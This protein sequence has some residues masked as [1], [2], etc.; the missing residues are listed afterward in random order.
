M[1]DSEDEHVEQR[2]LRPCE[3][4]HVKMPDELQQSAFEVRAPLPRL[5]HARAGRCGQRPAMLRVLAPLTASN[6]V[7]CHAPSV[8]R[9]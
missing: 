3:V 1:S 7:P 9:S 2:E 8:P 4:V 5:A 6:S